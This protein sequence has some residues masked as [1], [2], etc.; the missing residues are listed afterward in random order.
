MRI[1]YC[2]STI[3]KSS[4]FKPLG[5]KLTFFCSTLCKLENQILLF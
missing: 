1:Y 3:G 5:F 4:S 2:E